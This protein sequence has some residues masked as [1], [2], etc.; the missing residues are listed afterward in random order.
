MSF[1][2]PKKYWLHVLIAFVLLMQSFAMWHDAAHPF[3]LASEQCQQFGS[4]NHTPSLEPV[5]PVLISFTSH[6]NNTALISFNHFVYRQFT[7]HHAIRAPPL[8]S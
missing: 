8:F 5:N 6:A 4:I 2:I 1:H 7:D 3:H